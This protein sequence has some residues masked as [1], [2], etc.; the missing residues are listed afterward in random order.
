MS[1][2]GTGADE[3]MRVGVPIGDLLAGMY[4]AY[5]VGRRAARA[6]RDGTRRRRA[7]LAA[8][9]RSSGCTPSRAPA[10]RSPA[11]CRR[12]RATTTRRSARTACST[13]RTG[14]CRSRSAARACGAPWRR[15]SG[16]R[17]SARLREQR[18]AG[19]Q[20]RRGRRRRRRGLRRPA[21]APSCCPGWPASGCRPAR[22]AP[23]TGSTTGTR[24]GRRACSSTSTM[25]LPAPSP[26]PG[27][28]CASTRTPPRTH[29]APPT[30]GQH[31]ESVR[32]WLDDVEGGRQPDESAAT[33]P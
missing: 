29:Q 8:R 9:R 18:R 19:A 22:C 3:P 17:P 27:R 12:G 20:P 16:C 32:D 30:L 21:A 15:S 14:W 24:P 6:R 5:G 2:T 23:S 28:R 7:H 33:V 1:L 11:R 31:D 10:T 25:P 26:C 13:A 4:G